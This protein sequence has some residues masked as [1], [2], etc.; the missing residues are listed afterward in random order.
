MQGHI[1]IIVVCGAS[2]CTRREPGTKANKH[3]IHIHVYNPLPTH[4]SPCCLFHNIFILMCVITDCMLLKTLETSDFKDWCSFIPSN[5]FICVLYW[6]LNQHVKWKSTFYYIVI[7]LFWWLTLAL[8][9]NSL[10]TVWMCPWWAA[11]PRETSPVCVCRYECV[12]MQANL[13]VH[14][15]LITCSNFVDVHNLNKP[16]CR[17]LLYN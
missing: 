4:M 13:Q 17:V 11:I 7:T 2:L 12:I 15:P 10:W 9:S 5:T 8:A 14:V 16:G 6:Y 1:Y 3:N